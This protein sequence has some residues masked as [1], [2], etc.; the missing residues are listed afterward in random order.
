[1]VGESQGTIPWTAPS[2]IPIEPCPALPSL[3]DSGFFS[4]LIADKVPFAFADG[5]VRFLDPNFQCETLYGLFVRNDGGP[6]NYE[7]DDYLVINPVP[8]YAS[9]G[10]LDLG[11]TMS[12]LLLLKSARSMRTKIAVR[13]R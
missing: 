10:A 2:D 12:F 4:S 13:G 9:F 6:V 11:A 3:N 1:L 7:A 8:E 5:S